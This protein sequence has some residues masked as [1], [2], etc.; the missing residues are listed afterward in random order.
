[1]DVLYDPKEL[2]QILEGLDGRLRSSDFNGKLQ[3]PL[4]GFTQNIL[5]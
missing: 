3:K 5:L 1:M 4:K 2:D